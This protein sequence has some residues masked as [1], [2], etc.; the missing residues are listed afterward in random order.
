MACRVQP[1]Q[2]Q[3]PPGAIDTIAIGASSIATCAATFSRPSPLK[4]A[5]ASRPFATSPDGMAFRGECRTQSSRGMPMA[6][7]SPTSPRM[8]GCGASMCPPSQGAP[9]CLRGSDGNGGTHSTS[10]HSMSRRPWAGGSS[11]SW[12]RTDASMS[13]SIAC[14]SLNGRPIPMY[15]E[16][17]SNTWAHPSGLSSICAS[18][19]PRPHA[20]GRDRSHR[21]RGSSRSGSAGPSRCMASFRARHERSSSAGRPQPNPPSGWA[22]STATAQAALVALTAGR[23]STG[24]ALPES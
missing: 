10:P 20:R 22:C 24:S 17:S 15:Y 19:L 18:R 7:P 14:R 1:P 12:P 6:S 5:S 21:R 23:G 2:H 8:K 3:L 13:R 9:A 11:A 16:L 4:R